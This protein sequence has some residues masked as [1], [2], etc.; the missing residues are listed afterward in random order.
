MSKSIHI[1][2]L[3]VPFPL[4]YGGAIDM[5]YRIKA[6]HTLGYKIT[7]HCFEYGR[8]EPKELEKYASKVIYYP[9]KKSV[10]D[11]L[12]S[13]PFIVKS[14]QNNLLLQ[15][16]KRDNSPIIFEGIHTTSFLTDAELKNRIKLVRCHNIEHDYYNALAQRASG[17]KSIFYKSEAK[18]LAKYEAVLSEAS[19][20]LVIQ[21]KD[22]EHFNKI[23]P[24]THL[25]PASLPEIEVTE[26]RIVKD[27]MLF[28]G[29]LSVSEND[30]AA[31]WIIQN[32][33][34]KVEGIPLIIAGLNPSIELQNL[35]T[36]NGID[37]RS[38]LSQSEMD[39]LVS[40][41][42]IHVLYTNQA[43]GL[44][45]KLLSALQ[46]NGA[47]IVSS[48]MISGTELGEHC[49]IANSAH[50]FVK[51]IQD[52]NLEPLNADAISKRMA[53]LNKTYNTVNNCKLIEQLCAN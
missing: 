53:Q 52:C 46:S 43:T 31:Q 42:K 16:L 23:N 45:L 49:L 17:L 39:T 8:G 1:I 2:A 44:K 25:L 12:S 33:S 14:R 51:H 11:W 19:A 18:K 20:L 6:L 37:L 48:E 30:Y 15:N 34:T 28:H 13:T 24:N 41:A 7:L 50:E 26:H 27:Y 10:L 29:N 21:N 35:C 5:F 38:N 9:R 4:N 40:E 47:V 32:V 36:I 22:L 3:D